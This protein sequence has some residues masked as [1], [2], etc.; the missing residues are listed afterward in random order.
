MARGRRG[1]YGGGGG[2]NLNNLMKQAQKMQEEMEKAKKEIE[3]KSYSAS[4]GGG[5]V[6]V[7]C[8]GTKEITEVIIDPEALDPEEAD[9][10][11]DMIMSAVNEV[12]RQIDDE[13]QN[14]MGKFSG[15][16]GLPDMF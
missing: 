12:L 1:G 16:M 4:V 3:E 9:M 11:Q 10:V 13:M 15:G 5:M 14:S 6:K 8:K 7:T 2:Q